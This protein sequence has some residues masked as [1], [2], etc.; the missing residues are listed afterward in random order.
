MILFRQDIRAVR[1]IAAQH[2]G[3]VR[4][5]GREIIVKAPRGRVWYFSGTASVSGRYDHPHADR[6]DVCDTL[7]RQIGYGVE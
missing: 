6:Y 7:I 3:S 1:K 2:G 5:N 4:D